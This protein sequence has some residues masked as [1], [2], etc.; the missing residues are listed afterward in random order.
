MPGKPKKL[1]RKKYVTLCHICIELLINAAY[2]EITHGVSI[3]QVDQLW[4]SDCA[5][6]ALAYF[7][8]QNR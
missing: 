1:R 2:I 3:K 7:D 6:R 4:Q 8:L 5:M